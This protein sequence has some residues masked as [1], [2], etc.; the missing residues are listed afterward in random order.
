M[1]PT[2]I[3]FGANIILLDHALQPINAF[4]HRVSSS[5]STFAHFSSINSVVSYVMKPSRA[6][7]GRVSEATCFLLPL[8]LLRPL[9]LLEKHAFL[10]PSSQNEFF[11]HRNSM[12]C[13]C[14]PLLFSL[15]LNNYFS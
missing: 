9:H 8:N 6:P 2:I 14:M 10:S 4:A 1:F 11:N 5:L 15:V 3:Y 12:P 13:P 7:Q